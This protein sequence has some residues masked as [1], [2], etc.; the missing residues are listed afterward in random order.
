[1]NICIVGAGPAGL[2]AAKTFL[3]YPGISVTVFEAADR[4]GGMWRGRQGETGD[5]CDP[6]MRTNLSRF[7]VAFSDL[8]WHS[9]FSAPSGHERIPMFP[10]AHEVGKYL[11]MYSDKFKL[12]SVIQLNTKVVKA[13]R[14]DDSR[15]WKITTEGIITG[16]LCRTDFDYLVIASGFF[17]KRG[18]SFDPSPSKILPNVQHSSRFRRLHSL[19]DNAG[20]IVVIG[21]GISGSE[22]AATA[23]F[24]IS[25]ASTRPDSAST[26]HTNSKI[27]HVV[28]RPFYLL[29]RYIPTPRDISKPQDSE[30]APKFLPLDLV[31]YN[32]SR[33]GNGE[34][35]AATTTV[36]PEKARKGHEYM[37]SLLGSD[38]SDLGFPE[39]VYKETQMQ[40]PAYTGISD[41]YAEFVRSGIIIPV[42]GWVEAVKQRQGETAFDVS[43]KQY[44]PWHHVQASES[45]GSSTISNVVGIIEATGYKVDL[46]YLDADTKE[47]LDY[48]PSCPRI[49]FHFTQAST[50]GL[51]TLAAVGFYEGPFWGVMEMQ[52]RCIAERWARGETLL[53]NLEDSSG[54][55]PF[56]GDET[57]VMREALKDKRSLQVPQFWMSDYVGLVE[58]LARAVG[59]SR[60]DYGLGHQR[61]PI[62][63]ARYR[64]DWAD[65]EGN[66]VAREVYA[67]SRDDEDGKR[68]IAPAVFRGL[69]GVWNFTR[70]IQSRI[71]SSSGSSHSGTAHFSLRASNRPEIHNEY[72]YTEDG[73]PES[74]NGLS[75]GE[76]R[77]YICR[78]NHS[79]DSIS[80]G[81]LVESDDNLDYSHL[82][83]TF[84]APDH[85]NGERGWIANY[86]FRNRETGVE[87]FVSLEFRFRGANI[88][89]FRIIHRIMGQNRENHTHETWYERPKSEKVSRRASVGVV[90]KTRATM[91]DTMA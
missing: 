4:V 60:D 32:L 82:P 70:K 3:Q 24:Q 91:Y 49:P 29:P 71:T 85:N 83:W 8:D 9:V 61:G 57:R 18:R 30:T 28:N 31:L 39:L 5:K 56:R 21:G 6:E 14:S 65:L 52:A 33:R 84:R 17:D 2:V 89:T 44:D 63:P 35:S 47:D 51:P 13:T 78:Y 11:D 10:K 67:L 72:L 64:R 75:F 45:T 12:D 26:V 55:D 68:F 59:I 41:T 77:N 74:E 19:T 50:M 86:A 40:Y 90:T 22:A 25:D 36:P 16:R 81:F 1:M 37:R 15:S 54:P 34:I 43:L 73:E 66:A 87:I 62:F 42:Q 7:T 38:Q 69:Q 79:A 58:Q 76:T 23:A 88:D 27:Y 48:D 53:E 46:D 20:K 80:R